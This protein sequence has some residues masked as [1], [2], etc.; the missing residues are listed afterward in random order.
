M[1]AQL[2]KVFDDIP[3]PPG[4]NSPEDYQAVTP[5]DSADL[6]FRCRA[7]W[8]G[9]AGNVAFMARDGSTS[10]VLTNVPA[11]TWVQIRTNRIL[12]TGTTATGIVAGK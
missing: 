6:N 4:I 5:N 10:V 2:A 1:T 11:S 12:S 8:C 9:V 7:I 3:A